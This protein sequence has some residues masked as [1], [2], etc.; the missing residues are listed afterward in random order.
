MAGAEFGPFHAVLWRGG[1]PTDLGTLG[2]SSS[3]A[4][5]LSAG[6]EVVGA[7]D[8]AAEVF[9]AFMWRPSTGMTGLGHL[10]GDTFS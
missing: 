3:I 9:E 10:P 8:L 5:D 2:G 4:G 6:D 7:S 1:V